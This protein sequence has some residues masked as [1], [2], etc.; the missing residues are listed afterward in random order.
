MQILVDGGYQ[1]SIDIEA[2]GTSFFSDFEE[3]VASLDYLKKC[4][5]SLRS[6]APN[7]WKCMTTCCDASIQA[8]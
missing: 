1:G 4:R 6:Y 7:S 3:K 5:L 2:G 8:S